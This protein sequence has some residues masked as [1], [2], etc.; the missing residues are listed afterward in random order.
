MKC[1]YIALAFLALATQSCKEIKENNS[2][3]VKEQSTITYPETRKEETVDDY[4]G[5]R[6]EDPYRWLEDDNSDETKAWVKAQ[7]E[8]TDS[9]LDSIPFKSKI[10]DR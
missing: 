10:K 7:N 6:V 2:T 4:F 5:T 1:K 8:V 3:E 9:F